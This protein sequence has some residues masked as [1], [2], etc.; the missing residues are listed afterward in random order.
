MVV[1]TCNLRFEQKGKLRH[2]KWQEKGMGKDSKRE[3][4]DSMFM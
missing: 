1:H 3:N 4:L 2:G